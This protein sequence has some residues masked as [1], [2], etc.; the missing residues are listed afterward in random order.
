MH[1]CPTP[2]SER[3]SLSCVGPEKALKSP[4]YSLASFDAS[5]IVA[6]VDEHDVQSRKRQQA[7]SVG[8]PAEVGTLKELQWSLTVEKKNEESQ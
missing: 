5:R 8:H 6:L 3:R 2:S 4:L 1:R 7:L